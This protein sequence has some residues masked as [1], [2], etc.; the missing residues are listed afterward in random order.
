MKFLATAAAALSLALVASVS[1]AAG[2]GGCDGVFIPGT[3]TDLNLYDSIITDNTLHVAGGELRYSNIG[4]ADN[5]PLDLVVTVTSG[6]YI[7]IVDEWILN[8]KPIP[9]HGKNG[10]FGTINL[11]TAKGKPKSGEGNFQMCLVKEGTDDQV[12]VEQFSW[13]VYDLDERNTDTGDKI[14]IKEKL[15][16]DATQAEVYQLMDDTEI[17]LSCEDGSALPCT[18]GVRTVFHSST[19]GTG[20]DNPSDPDDLEDLQKARSVVF[21]FRDTSCW[22]FTYDHYCPVDQPGYSG[23]ETECRWYGGGNFLFAGDSPQIINEGVCIT[24]APT[25]APTVTPTPAPTNPPT[26]S[27]TPEPTNPPTPSPTPEPTNPP[28]RSPTPAPTPEPTYLPTPGPTPG[29]TYPPTANPTA[30]PS[31]GPTVSPT[32]GPTPGPTYPP[33]PDPTASPSSGPTV[34]LTPG[35]TPEPTYP[36][37]PGPT[38]SPTLRPTTSNPSGSP[39]FP[40][41][42]PQPCP[43][44][45]NVIHQVGVTEIDAGSAIQ[46]LSQDITSVTVR[47][48]Q[49][50]TPASQDA[51]YIFYN[52][53][54][55]AY[56]DK[57][58]KAEDVDGNSSYQDIT[59]QCYQLKPF[60]EL[61]ICVADND[62][63]LVPGQDNAEIPRCCDKGDM[64]DGTPAVCYK[65]TIECDSKCVESV[66]R[67]SLRGSA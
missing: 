65:V 23:P 51:D 19:A 37:T 32:A 53:R 15:I 22:Q 14:G 61:D 7:D 17:V 60:A 24:R 12:T 44:D 50:W 3:I 28:T 43:E 54:Y 11:Q 40:P 9:N 1:D 13:S 47:L 25:P 39:T 38:E 27:P 10:N 64:E 49:T 33:T 21:T 2:N 48:Y 67:R 57:C 16:M 66:G 5:Q 56:S 52:Y 18:G 59:I 29:P 62:G 58:Y 8:E 46:I 30:S 55:D 6:D 45:V 42:P 31:S 35:P 36:P 41:P 63:A 26:P 4:V 34:S 20:S